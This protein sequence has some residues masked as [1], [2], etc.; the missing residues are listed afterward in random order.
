MASDIQL[1]ESQYREVC[2]KLAGHSEPD[3]PSPKTCPKCGQ[4]M[5]GPYYCNGSPLNHLGEEG[6][7]KAKCRGSEHLTYVCPCGWHEW[8]PVKGEGEEES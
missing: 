5:R 7:A 6:N 1:T 8:A 2:A 3:K 4:V